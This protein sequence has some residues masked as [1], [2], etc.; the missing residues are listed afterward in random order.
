MSYFNGPFD[1]YHFYWKLGMGPDRLYRGTCFLSGT[2]GH[3]VAFRTIYFKP[4]GWTNG[5]LTLERQNKNAYT[6]GGSLFQIV[7]DF[8]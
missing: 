2:V 6:G 3:A 1:D 7:W 5:L 8:E 4:K